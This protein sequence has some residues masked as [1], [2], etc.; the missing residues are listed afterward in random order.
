[1]NLSRIRFALKIL[2]SPA[3][4]KYFWRW[5]KSSVQKDYFL[6]CRQPWITF[7]AVDFLDTINL[8]NKRIFE[9]GSGGSTLYWLDKG[10]SVV[11]IEH[12]SVW[13]NKTK[14]LISPSHRLD[15]RLV[16]PEP[17]PEE[18]YSKKDPANPDDYISSDE[19]KFSYKSYVCQIDEFDNGFFDVVLIDG[20]ARPSCIKH[21]VAKVKSGGVLILDNSDREYYTERTDYLLHDHF[22]HKVFFGAG[23]LGTAF[24]STSIYQ[25]SIK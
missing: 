7:D 5:V 14:S 3:Q 20:R 2:R 24:W 13:F 25:S 15:Y 21:S 11:S 22:F 9:Y 18:V 10:A 19:Q 17:E 8:Q 12:D 4:R 1:M 6:L 16:L 23:P